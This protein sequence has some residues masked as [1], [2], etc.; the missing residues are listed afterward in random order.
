MPKVSCEFCGK[1]FKQGLGRHR[2]ACERKHLDAAKDAAFALERTVGQVEGSRAGASQ[3][4]ISFLDAEDNVNASDEL[5]PPHFAPHVRVDDPAPY[6]VEN[7][8]ETTTPPSRPASPA[9]ISSPDPDSY[10]PVLND[11]KTEYHPSSRIPTKIESFV[12]YNTSRVPDPIPPED[13]PWE[14][15]R[16][17]LDFEVSELALE[18]ALS[19]K[20]IDRLIGIIHCAMEGNESNKF[21]IGSSGEMKDMWEAASVLRTRFVKENITVPYKDEDRVFEVQFRDPWDWALEIVRSPT[22]APRIHWDAVRLFKWSEKIGWENFVD[23]PWTAQAFWDAQSKLPETAPGDPPAKILPFILYADK[24]KLSSFGTAKGY[25]IVARFAALP[26]EIRNSDGVGGGRVVGW[27][28]IVHE[29]TGETNKKGFV[30]FKNAV[31]HESFLAFLRKIAAYSHTGCYVNG[32]D[33]IERWLWPLILLLCADYEEM[34][35]M[36]LI[37]GL[38]GH[39]PCPICL[40]PN[41]LQ[42]DLSQTFMLR[43]QPESESIV[44]TAQSQATL[45]AGEKMLSKYSLRSVNNAF[46]SMANTDLHRALSYDTLHFDDNGLWEDHFFKVFKTLI[47]VRDVISTID[48]HFDGMPRWSGLNHFKSV[49]NITFN[50]GSKN[51]DISKIFLFAA[52]SVLA[53]DNESE[54]YL[55]LRCLRSYLNIRMYADFDLHTQSTISAGHRELE[56]VFT[57]LI[58]DFIQLASQGL[59]SDGSGSESDGEEQIQAT[60]KSWNFIKL[61]IRKHLFP[62][63]RDKGVTRNFST[64]PNEKM[65]GP[66]KISYQRRT[67]FKD[68]GD[69]ILKADHYLLVSGFIRSNLDA[70][71][72]HVENLLAFPD[73]EDA[74]V[75]SHQIKGFD[76]S[77]YDQYRE[78]G[79]R[80]KPPWTFQ[81]LEETHKTDRAYKDFRIKL[82]KFLTQFLPAYK[83]ALPGGKDIRFRQSDLITEYRFLK[84]RYACSADWSLKTDYLRCNPKFYGSPRYD[85]VLVNSNPVPYFAR[86]IFLFTC[87]VEE[88][89]YPL[90]LIQPFAGVYRH[91][92]RTQKDT[93]LEL[94]RLKENLRA[95]CEFVSIHTIIR[96]AVLVHSGETTNDGFRSRDYFLFDVLDADMFLRARSD[97]LASPL[98]K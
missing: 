70:L 61:H 1:E 6:P 26:H 15:F 14:P 84:V 49:M 25:P 51:R 31:W 21:T 42:S 18:A 74:E 92:N 27:L 45:D 96:G 36:S 30:N 29:D 83:I 71:D 78:I 55:L 69:Q 76:T 80:V 77:E 9:P 23:E 66:L 60:V 85:C 20:Q 4:S 12:D 41:A 79:S 95:E 17:R 67:N 91:R 68:F 16:S 24:T 53:R 89:E 57:R 64:K 28:P 8:E 82:G 35:V 39:F 97:E 40:V 44:R 11:I 88:Q 63:I 59:D 7:H 37:R 81:A 50:D 13:K 10:I 48:N 73:P 86:L 33:D 87:V 94:L 19:R 32:G 98:A 56:E 58:Q 3:S 46:W 43:T 93:E 52:Q 72:Q 38:K 54:A 2:K 34:S 22:L 75:T 65:H 90:A 47:T 5:P 62:H